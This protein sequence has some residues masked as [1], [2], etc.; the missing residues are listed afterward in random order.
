LFAQTGA[1][2][3]SVRLL[4]R[5]GVGAPWQESPTYFKNIL[6]SKTDRYGLIRIDHLLPGQYTF[7][8]GATTLFA[9]EARPTLFNTSAQPNPAW[10]KIQIQA[11]ANFQALDLYSIDG[12]LVKT[13]KLLPTRSADIEVADIVPGHYWMVATGPTGAGICQIVL[14]HE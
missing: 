3:D 12:R 4:Y 5:P 9:G 8:K 6:G 1:L 11:E 10:Q 13:W 14:Q 7:G 2:E